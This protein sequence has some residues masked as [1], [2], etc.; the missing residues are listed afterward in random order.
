M[1]N[2]YNL[3]CFGSS[4]CSTRLRMQPER[5]FYTTARQTNNSV[6]IQSIPNI[7]ENAIYLHP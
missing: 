4:V 1:K 5:I 6:G 3:D 2:V 7:G